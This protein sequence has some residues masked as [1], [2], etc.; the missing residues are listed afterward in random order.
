MDH[1]LIFGFDPADE[2][3]VF[4]ALALGCPAVEVNVL[5]LGIA[6]HIL[7]YPRLN[8]FYAAFGLTSQ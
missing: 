1:S 8:I 6:G 5:D 4:V 3:V 2:P 7:F